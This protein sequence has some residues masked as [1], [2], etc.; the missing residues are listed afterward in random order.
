MCTSSK[1]DFATGLGGVDVEDEEPD[2]EADPVFDPKARDW[3]AYDGL[4]RPKAGSIYKDVL[5]PT[6]EVI[7]ELRPFLKNDGTYCCAV[8][9]SLKGHVKCSRMRSHKANGE[10]LDHAERVLV[11]WMLDGSRKRLA[12]THMAMPRL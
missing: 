2:Q 5:S 8:S 1:V 12:R 11:A 7:G 10:P 6:G 3:T 9:C 4:L